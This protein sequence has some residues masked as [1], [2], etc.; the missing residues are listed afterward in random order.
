MIKNLIFNGIKILVP[1][2]GCI[3]CNGIGEYF[4]KKP[5]KVDCNCCTNG[6]FM[7]PSKRKVKCK[8]C[9]GK[10]NRFNWKVK[11]LDKNPR[12]CIACNATGKKS[13]IGRP[14]LTAEQASLITVRD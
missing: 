7:L 8:A 1:F 13:S 2:N 3:P 14:V 10:G 12:L 9:N 6:I 11:V 4:A 5:I